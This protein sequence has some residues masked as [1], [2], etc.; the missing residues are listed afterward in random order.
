MKATI[1][2]VSSSKLWVDNELISEISTGLICY[3][4]VGIGDTE[5]EIKWMAKKIA[6]LRIFPDSADKMNL[7]LLDIGAEIMAVSQFTLY[8]DI[9]RG[10]RPSFIKAEAPDKAENLYNLFCQELLNNGIKKVAKGIFGANMKIEQVN[11]G[12]VTILVEKEPG[13]II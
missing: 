8:G 9:S 1:Q 12:P 6:G 11:E 5:N 2:R 10:F 3:L 7:S 13:N 4:G